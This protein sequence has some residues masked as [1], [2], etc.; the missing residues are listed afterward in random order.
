ML[1]DRRRPETDLPRRAGQADGGFHVRDLAQVL[2]ACLEHPRLGRQVRIEGLVQAA[3]RRDTAIPAASKG[4]PFV[5]GPGGDHRLQ[6]RRNF[7][8]PRE[9][10][11]PVLQ[12]RQPCGIAEAAPKLRLDSAKA[13]VAAVLRAVHVVIMGP[14]AERHIAG[15]PAAQD[16]RGRHDLH[17][18][19]RVVQA[20]VQALTL[21]GPL[22]RQQGQGNGRHGVQPRPDGRYLHFAHSRLPPV[23]EKIQPRQADDVQIMGRFVAVLARLAEARNGAVNKARIPCAHGLPPQ[24]QTLQVP[25]PKAF[26]E[27]I[28]LLQQPPQDGPPLRGLQLQRQA[29]LI[30][31]QGQVPAALSRRQLRGKG[32]I[33]IPAGPLDLHHVGAEIGQHHAAVLPGQ[34][35]GKINH[36][37]TLQCLFHLLSF[38]LSGNP[39]HAACPFHYTGFT[40]GNCVF[41]TDLPAGP[42]SFTIGGSGP[43]SGKESL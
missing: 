17:A 24:T 38:L 34:P 41:F 42:A 1:P 12:L 10:V 36:F 30:A 22:P 28:G 20:D 7:L 16:R 13:H 14:A 40:A 26:E 9:I 32:P 18:Q 39:V 11:L 31:V 6:F 5:A 19:G 33:R 3:Y 25:R 4:H 2:A 21:P 35:L 23:R 29:P 27:H 43:R 15:D 8:F 37:H